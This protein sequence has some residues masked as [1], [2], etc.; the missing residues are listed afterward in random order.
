MA[1]VL[2]FKLP[3]YQITELLNFSTLILLESHP[4]GRRSQL[5]MDDDDSL[6]QRSDRRGT[7]IV[8]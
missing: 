8:A 5:A 7:S 6:T 1:I 4:E 3:D 2:F